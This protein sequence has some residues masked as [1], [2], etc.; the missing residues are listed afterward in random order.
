MTQ[1]DKGRKAPGSGVGFPHG[2][3]KR[4]E[5]RKRAESRAAAKKTPSPA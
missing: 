2:K 4:T 1:R 5:R 3:D